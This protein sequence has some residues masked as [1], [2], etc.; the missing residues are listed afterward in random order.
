MKFATTVLGF[1]VAALLA[2]GT[3]MLCSSP[4]GPALLTQQLLFTLF[5][6]A[7]CI[8]AALVDYRKLKRF[9]WPLLVITIILLA[10][11]FVPHLGIKAGGARRWIGLK[12]M[13]FQPSE[14]AKLALIIAIA[15][16]AEHFQRQ[17][18]T[19][20]RG[21]LFPA[22]FIAPVIGLVFAEPDF[23]TT[24]LLFAVCAMMLIVAGARLTVIFPTVALGVLLFGAAVMTNEVRRERVLAF[25]YPERYPE[26]RWK[27][28][29]QREATVALGSGGLFGVG[30]GDGRQ[31]HGYVPANH[32]DFILSIVG[33]ELGLVATLGVVVAFVAIGACGVIIA[34]R[35]CDRF[36]MLLAC[37]I[38]FLLTL[39]AFINI[40]V[41]TSVLPNKGLALPFVS[42]GGSSVV[43]MLACVGV[44]F[45][46]ARY[47]REPEP[48]RAVGF[49]PF[50]REEIPST[51]LS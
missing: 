43:A 47:A 9:A 35:A 12:F 19:V 26:L 16:Y 2:L 44:L 39:Q 28:D 18:P 7:V 15:C 50:N 37:G 42:Y 29:Q 33:E 41:V 20:K 45:S 38:T 46:V 21:L 51:Q 49:N 8:A 40:G 30:L 27:M 23:G 32:T 25:F 11:V 5:G 6:A 34:S 36:G 1:C 13:N 31:K 24:M 4:K 10:A 48:K 17:M 14:L 3:V 22:L